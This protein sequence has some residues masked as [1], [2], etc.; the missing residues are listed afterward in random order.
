[1]MTM[2]M[3]MM[4]MMSAVGP[5]CRCW[6]KV[7][8]VDCMCCTVWCR[9][10][11]DECSRGT[12]QTDLLSTRYL[13]IRGSCRH[14]RP[15][16]VQ[17]MSTLLCRRPPRHRRR[18]AAPPTVVSFPRRCLPRPHRSFGRWRPSTRP[19]A[20]DAASMQATWS[21]PRRP[22]WLETG[23]QPRRSASDAAVHD[24]QLVDVR[25]LSA[26]QT[27]STFSPHLAPFKLPHFLHL[28]FPG[29]RSR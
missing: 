18:P 19:A 29:L 16:P 5:V 6:L 17:T 9:R 8:E 3:M 7:A 11:S 2:L 13:R 27:S 10:W 12:S 20:P 24:R 1:M 28:P 4:L 21:P 22:A 26:G 14:L 25:S 23:I 15:L